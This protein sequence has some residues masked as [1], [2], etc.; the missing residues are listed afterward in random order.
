MATEAGALSLAVLIDA[1][2]ANQK[3]AKAIFDEIAKLGEANV[4]RIYGDF[5]GQHLAGWNEPVQAL[6]ILQHQQRNNIKGK[7]ASD[8][9]LVIDA[10]DLM[11]KGKLDGVCLVSSDSD[12]TRLS[13]RLREEGLKV[14]GFGERKT[15]VA[16]RN[17]CSQ[18]IYVENLVA[19][20]ADDPQA[21]AEPP[22]AEAERIETRQRPAPVSPD[23][24]AGSPSAKSDP[25]TAVPPTAS[26]KEPASK[27]VPIIMKA[28]TGL[29]D[30][31]GWA[32]L[33]SVGSQ[34][35]KIAPDFDTRSYGQTKLKDLVEKGG[36]FDMRRHEVKGWLLRPKNAK[37]K[38]KST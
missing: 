15:P 29:D 17:A 38:P 25:A 8:I 4:R 2:N 11:H 13:Q 35:T 3:Y 14:Y 10:M 12:F 20:A 23:P 27:A 19:D 21:S 5:S 7:N 31:D 16:F 1:D 33:S 30:D 18:F 32:T 24:G 22:R 9:A 26:A 34:I 36:G 28:M 6:A 37:R